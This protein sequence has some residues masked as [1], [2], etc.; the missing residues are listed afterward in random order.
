MTP[1]ELKSQIIS[2]IKYPDCSDGII[3]AVLS[4]VFSFYPLTTVVED[5]KMDGN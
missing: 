5:Q 3:D 2:S 1:A 4:S